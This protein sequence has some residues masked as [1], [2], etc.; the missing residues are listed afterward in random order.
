ML[1]AYGKS[2]DDQRFID[3]AVH[4]LQETPSEKNNIL[5]SWEE[6]GLTSKNAFDSQAMIELHN[7]FCLRRRCLD[8]NIGSSLLHP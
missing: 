6:L 1:A 3:R 5:Q 8:C 7:S 2:R 4:L